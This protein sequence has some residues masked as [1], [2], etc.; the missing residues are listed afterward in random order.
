MFAARVKIIAENIE[1]TA[2]GEEPLNCVA[3][4]A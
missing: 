4:H 2:R 1:R 3:S